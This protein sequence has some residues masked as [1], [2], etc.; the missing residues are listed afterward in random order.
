MEISSLA[1]I[2]FFLL[3]KL[4]S[5]CVS[6]VVPRYKKSVSRPLSRFR[7]SSF[8]NKISQSEAFRFVSKP[9]S[10]ILD[11]NYRKPNGQLS[12]DT[13]HAE[14]V[15]IPDLEPAFFP[16]DPNHIFISVLKKKLRDQCPLILPLLWGMSLAHACW[17]TGRVLV[18]N[19][20]WLRSCCNRGNDVLTHVETHERQDI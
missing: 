7:F 12:V 17:R 1:L 9:H 14:N 18:A 3:L 19:G 5:I 16:E 11:S 15:A 13:L 2:D 10:L 4:S 6:I 8:A 20:F